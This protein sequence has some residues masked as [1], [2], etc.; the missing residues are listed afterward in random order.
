VP[1]KPDADWETAKSFCSRVA[2]LIASEDPH[3]YVTN[4]RKAK[5]SGKIFIDYLRNSRGSTSIAPYSAR[6][7]PGAP[8]AVPIRWDELSSAKSAAKYSL[9]SLSKRLTQQKRDP[10]PDYHATK[11]CLT[12]GRIEKVAE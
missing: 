6:A 10:W 3:H 12:S 4:P 1:L 8:V 5:R 11:Q 2:E 7:R 9:Q